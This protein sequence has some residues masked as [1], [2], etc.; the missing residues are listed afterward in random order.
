MSIP[1]LN[2]ISTIQCSQVR[3]RNLNASIIGVSRLFNQ[4]NFDHGTQ[5][6]NLFNQTDS[7]LSVRENQRLVVHVALRRF[8]RHLTRNGPAT[9][10]I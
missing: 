3:K 9:A 8:L 6:P 7:S 5:G 10:S 4:S 1:S 2:H